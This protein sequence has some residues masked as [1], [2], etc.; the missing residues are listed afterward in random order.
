M[1]DLAAVGAITLVMFLTVGVGA[2]GIRIA[3]TPADFLVAAR[4][5]PPALNAA[6][7]SGEYLSAASFLGIAGLVFAQGLGSLWYSV[8]YAAGYLV[9]LLLVAAPLRRFG[10][11]TIP[12]F[13][14]GRLHSAPLRQ[15]ST[16]L[17]LIIGWFYLLPQMD[18][19][20][21][22][23]QVV[24]G[25]PYWV[26]VVILGVVVSGNIA[27][28]GMK[29]V[30]FVQAFQYWLKI[31]AIGIPTAVLLA[32]ATHGSM[33]TNLTRSQ[34]PAFQHA[35]TVTIPQALQF[36]VSRRTGVVATGTLDGV[37]GQHA[38]ITLRPGTHT[39]GAGA[40]LTF[41]AGTPVPTRLGLVPT[42]TPAWDSPFVAIGSD[43]AHPIAATYGL[44]V[45]TFF[46]AI[47]LPHI[48]VRFYTNRDGD[49]A[50]RTTLIVLLLLSL[51]YVFPAILGV[52]GRLRAPQLYLTG[53]TDGIV[54]ALPSLLLPGPL[55]VTLAA[56]VAAGAFAA[57]LSTSS[58][59]LVSVAGALSH[60]VLNGGVR[61]F[62]WCALLAGAVAVAAALLV[63]NFSASVLVGWAFAIA[64]SSFCPLLVLGIWWRDLTWK[65]AMAGVLIG[66]GGCCGAIIATMLGF[67]HTGWGAVLL[68]FP[69]LWTVPIAFLVMIVVSLCTRHARPADVDQMLFRIHLPEALAGRTYRP[70]D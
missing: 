59:L 6:A 25:T 30:T 67:A 15:A 36:S 10:A 17:V 24:L 26:G 22:T 28:G 43:G 13:A 50:R 39:A 52:L 2:R 33:M 63:E 27:M 49:A 21:L 16:V 12:D 62:R 7:I 11:Y 51:F 29:G 37:P 64:A 65:G 61:S 45:A 19:A 1:T 3:R 42:H 34:A 9:L 60:D 23:L 40:K 48:L 4:E 58:G 46:G 44:I 5:V 66:G 55:G 68:G 47:G 56:L 69:A 8:G 20:G 70:T 14:G 31:C 53:N 38:A 41:T 57:F 32:F 54:L 18:G 35:T